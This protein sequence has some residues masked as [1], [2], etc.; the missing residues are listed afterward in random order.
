MYRCDCAE[1]SVRLQWYD[2]CVSITPMSL[3]HTLTLADRAY[4][5]LNMPTC[6]MW[7]DRDTVLSV[8][9]ADIARRLI[10]GVRLDIIAGAGHFPHEEFPDRFISVLT[11]FVRSTAPSVYDPLRWRGILREGANAPT[12]DPLDAE[13]PQSSAALA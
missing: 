12:G 10:P 4:L 5:A 13:F 3:E 11:D 8:K 7:G 9:Q 2:H 1:I 6:V